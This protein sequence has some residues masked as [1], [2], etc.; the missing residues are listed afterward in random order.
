ML[1][2]EGLEATFHATIPIMHLSA[3]KD[4]RSTFELGPKD[5]NTL[6]KAIFL[7][8]VG[9]GCV[10]EHACSYMT[11]FTIRSIQLMINT[12]PSAEKKWSSFGLTSLT[13]SGGLVYWQH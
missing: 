10:V 11:I 7:G 8:R 9:L 13:G 12:K 5:I 3:L 2:L 4:L 6:E 1:E